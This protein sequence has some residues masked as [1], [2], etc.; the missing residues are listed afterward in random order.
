[1]QA[2]DVA[3]FSALHYACLQAKEI[4]RDPLRADVLSLL[5]EFGA[6]INMQSK[7]GYSALHLLG[8]IVAFVGISFRIDLPI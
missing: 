5:V 4:L 3:G 8:T 1:M 2:T 6:D 7:A